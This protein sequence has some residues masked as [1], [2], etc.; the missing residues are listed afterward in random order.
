MLEKALSTITQQEVQIEATSRTDRGVHALGQ[1]IYFSIK[2]KMHI[3]NLHDRLNKLLPKSIRVNIIKGLNFSFHPTLDAKSKTYLY[4]VNHSTIFS[5]ALRE[6][7]WH[8]YGNLNEQMMQEAIKLI[9]GKK[10]FKGLAN[11]ND[12][13]ETTRDVKSIQ[14]TKEKNIICFY[15]KAD[16]FLYKMVRNI[17]GSIIYIGLKK[18]QLSDLR[19]AILTKDRKL[20]GPCAPS[21][22]LYLKE[23][24]L[25]DSVNKLLKNAQIC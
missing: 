24:D 10:D 11:S 25:K 12:K 18:I 17:V 8:I 22:G 4:K 2:K 5:P 14:M 9:V 13:Q 21:H 7:T 6:Q 16:N 15:I 20:A 19:S 1:I 3:P 23:I